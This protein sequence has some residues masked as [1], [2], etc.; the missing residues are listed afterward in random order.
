MRNGTLSDEDNPEPYELPLRMDPDTLIEV[1]KQGSLDLVHSLLRRIVPQYTPPE[2]VITIVA[3]L[4]ERIVT[5]PA[6]S[7]P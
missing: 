3:P 5:S 4:S 7:V 1:A 2:Q 6:V